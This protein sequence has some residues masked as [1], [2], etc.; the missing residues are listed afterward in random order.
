MRSSRRSLVG[1]QGAQAGVQ[2]TATWSCGWE[3]VPEEDRAPRLRW[4]R[5]EKLEEVQLEMIN[6]EP[7]LVDATESLIGALPC[8]QQQLRHGANHWITRYPNL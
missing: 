3:Y 6:G 5:L 2:Q 7:L 1:P 4:L 8:Y